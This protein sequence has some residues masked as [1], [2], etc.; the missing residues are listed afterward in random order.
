MAYAML[1]CIVAADIFCDISITFK[2]NSAIYL[3]DK[4]FTDMEWCK[5]LL[6]INVIYMHVGSQPR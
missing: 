1:N 5:R 3:G 2:T 4:T 6:L